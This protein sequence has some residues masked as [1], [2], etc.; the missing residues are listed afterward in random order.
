MLNK[1]CTHSG[2]VLDICVWDADNT[3]AD[4]AEIT[5]LLVKVTTSLVLFTPFSWSGLP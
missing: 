4:R 2:R 5:L 3:Q 1:Y